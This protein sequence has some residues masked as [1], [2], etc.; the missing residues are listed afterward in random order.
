MLIDQIYWIPEVHFINLGRRMV[1]L[2]QD[3]YIKF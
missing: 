1:V 2:T 3:L